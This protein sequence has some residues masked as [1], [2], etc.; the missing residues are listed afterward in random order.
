[1]FFGFFLSCLFFSIL[2][3]SS[4]S[5]HLSSPFLQA[6]CPIS[7]S[8]FRVEACAEDVGGGFRPPDGVILCHNHLPSQVR[9]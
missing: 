7:R 5:S 3:L 6:G 8:F 1:L 2:S 4:L 9:K